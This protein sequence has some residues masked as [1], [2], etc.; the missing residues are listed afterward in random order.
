MLAKIALKLLILVF[1]LVGC[2][3]VPEEVRAARPPEGAVRVGGDLYLVPAGKDPSGCPWYSSWSRHLLVG[4][5]MRYERAG[6][7][8]TF[9]RNEAD[10]P[11][12]DEG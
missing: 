6:G 11:P 4:Q 9:D 8:W 12:L 5:A 2:E 7:G 10:C 3:P 1:L